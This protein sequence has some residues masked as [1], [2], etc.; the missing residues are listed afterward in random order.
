MENDFN[1]A[2]PSSEES[3]NS[4]RQ[5]E[6]KPEESFGLAPRPGSGGMAI[7]HI[8]VEK[9]RPNPQQPRVDFDEE[10]LRELADSI[11]EFGVLQPL[12]V[13]KIEIETENGT[14]VEYELIAGE[15]RLMA[16]KIA[17]LRTVPVI[18]RQEPSERQKLE[19]A[20]IENIQRADLNPIEAARA[21]ARLQ[22]EFRLTQ[23]EIAVKVG[24]SREVIANALR[25]L[26]LPSEIQEAVALRHLS[27]SQAR[28]LLAVSDIISQ[29]NLFNEILRDNLSVREIRSRVRGGTVP[30]VEAVVA[31]ETALDPETYALKERLEEALGTKVD[32]R[33]EGEAGKITINFYSEEE[34]S[35]ILDRLLKENGNQSPSLPE[36]FSI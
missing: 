1:S 17:G 11:R 30:K 23:R 15:R 24:K 28:M 31:V 21:F 18:V 19:I 2:I 34:L 33:R 26:N 4:G 10:R 36:D 7:F 27:E 25:L 29:Q 12:V 13:S 8:E 35:A 14:I 32:L 20:I 22:D 6:R 5:E 9:I 3:E 16:A